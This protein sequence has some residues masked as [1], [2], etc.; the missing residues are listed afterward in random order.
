MKTREVAHALA[1]SMVDTGRRMHVPTT[2]IITDM[3]Q[4]L[5][6][7]AGNANEVDESVDALLGKGPADL[8]KV[9]LEL[10]A[11]LLVLT[12]REPS[13]AGA[14]AR[15]QKAID[16]GAGL[17]KFREM[18]T[19][20]GG[21]LD[22]PRP[23]APVSEVTSPRPGYVAAMDTEVLGRVVIELGGG[24]KKLGD[25]LDLSTGFEMLVRLG[26]EIEVGQPLARV[27]AKPDAA[28]RVQQ[29][30]INAITLSQ[31][32]SLSPTLIAERIT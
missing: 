30:I 8:M 23:I 29:E 17:E 19:A 21:D 24:R 18:V 3:N 32:P 11:E 14:K 1:R 28:A 25:V 9:T 13:L 5:G 4:P 15:L 12:K 7:M 10:G 6:R 16:S 27:F 31:E 26:D 2:A 20:Q 22:A